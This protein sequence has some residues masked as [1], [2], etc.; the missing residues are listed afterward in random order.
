MSFGIGFYED[1][2]KLTTIIES[3]G[4]FRTNL[5]TK[6]FSRSGKYRV[7]DNTLEIWK[8]ATDK[9]EGRLSCTNLKPADRDTL[10]TLFDLR[11]AF[12]FFPDTVN[13][14]TFFEVRWTDIGYSEQYNQTDD[15]YS[16]TI[17]LQEV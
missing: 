1:S 11:T 15:R 13:S 10:K 16:L 4:K 12:F 9:F 2:G 5:S 3:E 8:F 14:S 7:E 17:S 6:Y